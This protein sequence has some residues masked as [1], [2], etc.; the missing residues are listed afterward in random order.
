MINRTDM[1]YIESLILNQK[2]PYY[3]LNELKEKDW[4]F[5]YDQIDEVYNKLKTHFSLKELDCLFSKQV[6]NLWSPINYYQIGKIEN[7]DELNKYQNVLKDNENLFLNSSFDTLF[8]NDKVFNGSIVKFLFNSNRSY[9]AKTK[10]KDQKDNKIIIKNEF[11]NAYLIQGID[12][13]FTNT[14][15]LQEEVIGIFDTDRVSLYDFKTLIKNGLLLKFVYDLKNKIAFVIK[16]F[17]KDRNIQ[18]DDEWIKNFRIQNENKQLNKEVWKEEEEEEKEKTIPYEV[19]STPLTL[20]NSDS[21]LHI[22]EEKYQDLYKRTPITSNKDTF[23]DKTK[24]HPEPIEINIQ[25]K[26]IESNTNIDSSIIKT[27][28]P[29][30]NSPYITAKCSLY[31]KNNTYNLINEQNQNVFL[32]VSDKNKFANFFNDLPPQTLNDLLNQK[33]YFIITGKLTNWNPNTYRFG[34]PYYLKDL[35]FNV[36]NSLNVLLMENNNNE[37]SFKKYDFSK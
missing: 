16:F 27:N 17:N 21:T 9:Y 8:F 33:S 26:D 3:K 18:I 32:S 11:H 19:F 29:Y 4:L 10:Q 13:I 24:N 1:I 15:Y 7:K 28:S 23:K 22:Y 20:Q 2:I 34:Y 37:I 14:N 35:Y 5:Y 6:F 25:N 36:N 31:I 12:D 30:T